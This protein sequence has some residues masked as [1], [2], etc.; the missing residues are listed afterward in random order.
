[1]QNLISTPYL[2]KSRM[3]PEVLLH[4]SRSAAPLILTHH[5]GPGS[6]EPISPP[7]EPS[8]Q[9]HTGLQRR[10]SPL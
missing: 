8:M 2:L 9:T 10:A 5:L 3:G 4:K 6:P 7:S 1:M